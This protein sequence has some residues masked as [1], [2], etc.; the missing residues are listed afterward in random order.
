VGSGSSTDK[1][2]T[3]KASL[4]TGHGRLR[5]PAALVD[6]RRFATARRPLPAPV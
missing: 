5:S 1:A 6:G 4:L 3:D 2:L